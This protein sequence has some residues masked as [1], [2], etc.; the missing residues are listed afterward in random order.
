MTRLWVEHADDVR[1][2][3]ARRLGSP[4]TAS[5]VEDLLSDTYMVVWRRIDELPSTER[6]WIFV[7]ARNLV[8]THLRDAGRRHVLLERLAM[9]PQVPDVDPEHRVL[10]SNALAAAW[11]AL[12]TGDREALALIAWDGLSNEEAAR[13]LGCR[14]TTFAVRLHRARRRLRRLLDLA[15]ERAGGRAAPTES[16]GEQAPMTGTTQRIAT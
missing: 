6:P 11:R 12:P 3:I 14:T 7:V 4:S 8:M 13:V 10:A 15:D 2:F 9:Q 5:D 1:L 16:T